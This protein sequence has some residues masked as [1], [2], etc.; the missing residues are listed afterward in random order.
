MKKISKEVSYTSH[1]KMKKIIYF[2]DSLNSGGAQRQI[3]GLSELLHKQGLDISLYTYH[4]IPFYKP[5]LDSLN[6]TNTV[7]PNAHKAGR[8]PW[9]VHKA[10]KKSKADIVIAYLNIPS[11]LA[12]LS[13]ML[14]CKFKLIVSER[15]TTQSLT[16]QEKI[17]FFLYRWADHIVCNSYSQKDFIEAH[18]PRLLPKVTVITN[19]VDTTHFAPNKQKQQHDKLEIIS[20]G[21]ITPQKNIFRFLDAIQIVKSKGFSFHVSWYGQCLGKYG[22]EA[23]AYAQKLHL[24]DCI[25]FKGQ[26]ADIKERYLESDV[27]ILPSTYEGFPNVLCEA[28]SCGLPVLCSDVCDNPTIVENGQNGLLFDPNNVE[29]IANAVI[30]FLKTPEHRRNEMAKKSRELSLQ[31][32]SEDI[33]THKYLELINPENN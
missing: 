9:L 6:I 11:I 2:I 8:R 23:I 16:R 28:M 20:V 21:R 3:V 13:K 7:I 22:E 33:F 15:N 26:D 5:H 27:F 19:Y 18:Y 14:G 4:D 17:K 24:N 25:S 12:C 10:L 29:D 30:T 32:F 1:S 31:K